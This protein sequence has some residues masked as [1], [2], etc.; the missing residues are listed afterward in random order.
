MI[1]EDSD[2]I[3]RTVS[4]LMVPLIQTMALYVY[5]HGHI[6]P[7][8][9]F[10]GGCIFASSFILLTVAFGLKEAKKRLRDRV[11]LTFVGL[12]VFIYVFTG[13]LSTLLGGEFLNYGYLS[14]VFKSD[15][16]MSRYYGIAIIELGVQITVSA[17]MVSI[18]YELVTSGT[19][20]TKARTKENGSD[21]F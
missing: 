6:S 20:G 11:Y 3:I 17:S 18:F 13:V 14:R 19:R 1:K 4:R 7:G 8:G 2:V 16:V 9:G 10:Q 12:G 5:V 15:R 21:P